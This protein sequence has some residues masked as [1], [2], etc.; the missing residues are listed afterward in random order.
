MN[1][2]S[3]VLWRRNKTGK[4][5]WTRSDYGSDIHRVTTNDRLINEYAW[6][7]SVG[8]ECYSGYGLETTVM[9]ITDFTPKALTDVKAALHSGI[10]P[11]ITHVRTPL[12]NYVARSSEYGTAKYQERANYVRPTASH[13]E[14]FERYRSYLRALVSHAY[15]V[16]DSMER[17]QA[18]DPQLQ[19]WEGMKAAA[20]AAD[21]DPGNDR[22]GASGLSHIGGSAAS[23]NMA[24]EQAVNCGLL[25]ADPGQPWNKK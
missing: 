7:T 1:Q 2:P 10:K 13:K 23:L 17:H 20:Y 11:D 15:K 19:D 4:G 12:L 22:V 18:S 25:P 3:K 6:G 8:P 5:D 24:L 9:A 16:L 21:T 14:D